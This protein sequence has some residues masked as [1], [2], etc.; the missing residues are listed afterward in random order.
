MGGFL[1]LLLGIGLLLVHR[2]RTTP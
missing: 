1:G 2:A